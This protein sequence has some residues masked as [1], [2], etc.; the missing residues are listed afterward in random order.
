NAVRRDCVK[1]FYA[2]T[3]SGIYCL[4]VGEN[5]A[6]Y[7]PAAYEK[8]SDDWEKYLKNAVLDF[9]CSGRLKKMNENSNG[10]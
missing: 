1:A 6:K 2:C 8:M 10:K 4:R 9:D 5:L 7:D 3:K